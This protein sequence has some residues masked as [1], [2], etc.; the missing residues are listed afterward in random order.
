MI[1]FS[2][3]ICEAFGPMR[4]KTLPDGTERIETEG[5]VAYKKNDEYHRVGGPA[6]IDKNGKVESWYLNGR[7]H[8]IDGPAYTNN[9]VRH[10]YLNGVRH[11]TDGPAITTGKHE[12]YW[13]HGKIF[14]KE[15]FDKHFGGD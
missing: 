9:G 2:R 15:E 7:R 13:V 12:E 11:R 8:R 10:W 6:F 1:K 5:F 4:K 14:S 3:V